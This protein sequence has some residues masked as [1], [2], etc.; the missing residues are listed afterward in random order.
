[1]WVVYTSTKQVVHLLFTMNSSRI[2]Q[3]VA[4]DIAHLP[5]QQGLHIPPVSLVSIQHLQLLTLGEGQVVVTAGFIVV[6]RNEDGALGTLDNSL[7][8]IML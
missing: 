8:T 4:G 3:I 6:Q 5:R 7:L 1:M 2:R